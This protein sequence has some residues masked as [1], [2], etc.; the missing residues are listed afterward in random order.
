M[1]FIPPGDNNG[2]EKPTITIRK[3]GERMEVLAFKPHSYDPTRSYIKVLLVKRG[4]NDYVVWS[5]DERAG[6]YYDGFYRDN[7]RDALTEFNYRGG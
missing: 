7:L 2:F 5:K 3:D 1:V 4:E 6:D